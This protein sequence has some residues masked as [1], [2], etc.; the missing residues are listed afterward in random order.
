MDNIKI[1]FFVL[2]MCLFFC[3][4]SAYAAKRVALVIGNG[5]YS[6][7]P[8]RNPVNDAK[9]VGD[10]LKNLGFSVIRQSDADRRTMVNAL[11]R[12]GRESAG[13]DV[14]LFFYAGHGMQVDGA[15]YLIPVKADIRQ[16]QDV[17]F[18]AVDA[19]RFLAALEDAKAGLNIVVLDACRD[20]P[21]STFRS[22]SRGLA[23]VRGISESIVVYATAPGD[24]A[25]DGGG[26]HSPFTMALLK[27][28][29]K[30][31]VEVKTLFD[32]V[33]YTVSQSTGGR[34]RPWISSSFYRQ[35][36][37]RGQGGQGAAPNTQVA[38]AR[39]P[40]QKPEPGPGL[41]SVKSW[42]DPTTGMEFVWV[43]GGCY[44]MGANSGVSDEKP[45]HEV[46]VDGFWLG[47]YEVTQAEWQR[48]MGSNPSRFK[49][50]RNPV[51]QVSWNDA[52][53]FIKRL[54]A[55][56]NGT[57][58]L[59]TEA[60]WE[61]AARS[62]GKDE[63]YAGG[64]DVDRVAWYNGNSGNKTHPVGTKAPNGLG[65]YDMSGNVWEWCQDVYNENAYSQH[66][67]QNPIYSGGGVRR[68]DRGGGWGGYAWNVRA[69]DRRGNSQGDRLDFLG[70]RLLRT[71]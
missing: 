42:R 29:G 57:F 32:T 38:M 59:P 47:K 51:E 9:A 39:V 40:G 20:N 61:Y 16:E 8:L 41:P 60:E 27:E 24:V 54:N 65:L 70:F 17:E 5:G 37:L 4:G 53:E 7:S 55:K 33:G 2:W 22:A 18:E 62:G 10:A 31:V 56:G 69:A 44:Q 50:D 34:Q 43:P 6:S 23:V 21:F 12:F 14:A 63:K 25:A 66:A 15:N 36:F 3:C 49:G 71:N 68:V 1:G 28:I 64:N 26:S 30:P 11:R 19:N 48:V 52:Q 13:A 35:C 67:R 46:C 58:R 45:V